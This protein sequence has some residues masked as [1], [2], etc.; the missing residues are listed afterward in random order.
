MIPVCFGKIGFIELPHRTTLQK[1]TSFTDMCPGY[2]PDVIQQF[3]FELK[4]DTK[5][6]IKECVYHVRRNE[7]QGR[8][9]DQ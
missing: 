9:G 6:A 3:T 8:V 1:Y 4:V 5:R 7:N 2:N